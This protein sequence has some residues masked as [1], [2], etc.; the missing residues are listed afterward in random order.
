MFTHFFGC[1]ASKKATASGGGGGGE[2]S[3]G[4]SFV[5]T[6]MTVTDLDSTPIGTGNANRIWMY[7]NNTSP[8]REVQAVDAT[9]KPIN[10][11]GATVVYKLVQFSGTF[12]EGGPKV[13]EEAGT[14]PAAAYGIMRYTWN[15]DQ[16]DTDTAGIYHETWDV[17]LADGNF[18]TFSGPGKTVFEIRAN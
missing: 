2:V 15:I 18:I 8:A 6:P 13:V 14:L 1:G 9:G 4:V 11:T 10:L 16:S 12:P 17:T 5:C 3:S 7:Q